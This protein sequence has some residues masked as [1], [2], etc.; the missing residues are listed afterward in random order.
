MAGYYGLSM[1]NNAIEAYERGVKPS[2]RWSKKEIIETLV[3]ESVD[4]RVV[5]TALKCSAEVLRENLLVY[6]EWHH[7]S[8]RY[9]ATPFFFVKT[10]F[11]DIEREVN[12][13]LEAQNNYKHKKAVALAN[14]KAKELEHCIRVKVFYSVSNFRGRLYKYEGTG[15]IKGDWCYLTNGSKKS[16]LSKRFSILERLE[17]LSPNFDIKEW[18]NSVDDDIVRIS[19]DYQ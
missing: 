4:D 14:K 7:T 5:S 13:L 6:S 2:S 16:V 11:T 15:I 17:I 9:N 19:P 12:K 3:E 18:V 8:S 1:S 10:Y